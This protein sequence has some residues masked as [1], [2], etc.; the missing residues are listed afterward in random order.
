MTAELNKFLGL[1]MKSD[2]RGKGEKENFHKAENGKNQH[3]LRIQPKELAK[4]TKR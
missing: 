4:G 2:Y 1:Q 3:K